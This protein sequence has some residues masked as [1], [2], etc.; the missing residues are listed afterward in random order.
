MWNFCGRGGCDGGLGLGIL[1]FI[2][3]IFIWALIIAGIVALIRYIKGEKYEMYGRHRG[4]GMHHMGMGMGMGMKERSRAMDILEERY[5]KGEID[6]KEFD[7]RKR[8]L[9]M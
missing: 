3:M 9:E 1:G 7:E 8:D 2:L 4:M 6:K 5:A